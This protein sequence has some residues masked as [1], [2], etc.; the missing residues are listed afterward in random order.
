LRHRLYLS[1][2]HQLLVYADAVNTLGGSIHTIKE[3]TEA[4]VVASKKT[5]LQVNA[6]KTK[7][8]V[9]SQ[10]QNVG[11]NYNIKTGK[12]ILSNGVTVRIFGNNSNKSKFH[13]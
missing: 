11:Q 4:L 1:G 10:D 3:N 6:E 8:V 13:L 7:Y 5:G 12:R 2:T 9:M